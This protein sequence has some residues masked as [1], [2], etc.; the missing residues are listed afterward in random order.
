MGAENKKFFKIAFLVFLIFLVSTPQIIKALPSLDEQ[1]REIERKIQ[2]TKSAISQK[3]TE[4]SDLQSQ[5]NEIN[6]DIIA[7]QSNINSL[8]KEISFKEKEIERL[9]SEIKNNEE[10]I[11]KNKEDLK[12]LIRLLYEK[13]NTTTL[14]IL[15]S[16]VSIS[17]FLNQEEYNRA[18][19]EK[20]NTTIG[21]IRT[22]KAQLEKQ[23]KEQETQKAELSKKKSALE[24]EKKNQLAQK[25]SKDILL[26]QTRNEQAKYEEILKESVKISQALYAQRKAQGR[27][28]SGG[29][30]GYPYSAIDVPDPWGFL[31][32]EC[33]SY[34]AWYWN[35]KLGKS[36]YRGPGPSGTGNAGNW[37]NLAAMNGARV[38]NYPVVGAIMVWSASQAPPVGHVAIVEKIYGDGTVRV[39]QYN[40]YPPYSYS[41]MDISATGHLFIIK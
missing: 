10:R 3:K 36:W 40:W 33:T 6:K 8:E 18:I 16:T 19:Q 14:E 11:V 5:I 20:I 28:Y 25:S 37:P 13:G 31:T 39:S 30:G 15:A 26:A 23:K 9:T 27:N 21:E 41:E 32:R 29:S 1:I 17:H 35:V 12:A 4:A 34:V 22:L 2:E 38:V 24:I 7:T